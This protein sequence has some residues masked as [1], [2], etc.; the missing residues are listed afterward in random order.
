MFS[1]NNPL[2][3]EKLV[4]TKQAEIMNEIQGY[5]VSEFR[6]NLQYPIK[7]RTNYRVWI[8]VGAHCAAMVVRITF[9]IKR[10][11]LRTFVY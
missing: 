9:L 6:D 10:T 5:S 4:R 1:N 2:L 7:P 11:N 8:F 3:A